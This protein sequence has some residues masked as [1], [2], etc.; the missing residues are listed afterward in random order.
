MTSRITSPCGERDYAVSA[1]NAP[2]ALTAFA[3][4]EC[5]YTL[6][7][8][9]GTVA[10]D[11]SKGIAVTLHFRRRPASTCSRASTSSR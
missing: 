9:G 11:Q 4:G 8:A 3:F 10:L 2:L 5:P 7:V 6:G 1:G